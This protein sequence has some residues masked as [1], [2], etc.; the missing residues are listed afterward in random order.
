[1]MAR[2]SLIAALGQPQPCCTV[3]TTGSAVHHGHAVVDLA[4]GS[5]GA[6]RRV[7]LERRDHL[8]ARQAQELGHARH[9]LRA[10]RVGRLAAAHDQVGRHALERGGQHARPH[11]RVGLVERAIVDR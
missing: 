11:G 10:R 4:H 9:G 8:H 1:M 5:R 2:V 3:T 7:R 6:G